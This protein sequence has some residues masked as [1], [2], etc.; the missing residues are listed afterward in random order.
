[1]PVGRPALQCRVRWDRLFADLEA[2]F[3]D[4]AD[5]QAA[6]EQADRD[7]VATGAVT[8]VQRLGGALDRRMR[9]TVLGGREHEG[10]L[11]RVGRDFLLIEDDFGR[12]LLIALDAVTAVSGLTAGTAPQ[13]PDRPTRLDLRRALRSVARDRAVVAVSTG[14]GQIDQDRPEI[15]GT[16]DRV[17]ADFIEIAV[18][19]VGEPRRAGLVRSVCLVP[20]RAIAVVRTLPTG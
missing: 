17:G 10:L 6:A 14:Q 4:L 19:P 1:M 9:V 7:R 15:W 20:L 18:H 8:V 2:R 12:D 11:R 3:D 5:E 16:V 13:A